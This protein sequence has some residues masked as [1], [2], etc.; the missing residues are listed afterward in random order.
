MMRIF[1]LLVT[2]FAVT[3][4]LA[5]EEWARLDGVLPSLIP[6]ETTIKRADHYTGAAIKVDA[7]NLVVAGGPAA[8]D[9]QTVLGNL[10]AG[11]YTGVKTPSGNGGTIA[12]VTAEGETLL[13][14]PPLP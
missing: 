14:S 7:S 8:A 1:H 13:V 5:A 6:G 3:S 2:S 4:A 10:D 9:V 12:S 11:W